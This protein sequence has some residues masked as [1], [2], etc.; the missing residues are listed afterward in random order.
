MLASF[1]E[2]YLYA[3]LAA[4]YD[5]NKNATESQKWDGLFETAYGLIQDQ[6]FKDKWRGGD[7]HLTSEFQPRSYRY[8]FK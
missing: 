1:P 8:S 3:T 2:G 7:R 4:Y 5:K 6:N